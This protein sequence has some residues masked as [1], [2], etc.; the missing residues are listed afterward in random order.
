MLM[1]KLLQILVL[2]ALLQFAFLENAFAYL[3]PGTGSYIFQ[4]LLAGLIGGLFTIKTFWRKIKNFVCN[5][6]SR[7]RQP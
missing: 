3:D 1:R 6:F 7:K 4:A 2:I 5:H